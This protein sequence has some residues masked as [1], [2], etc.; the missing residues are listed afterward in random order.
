MARRFAALKVIIAPVT[1]P[2]ESLK[3]YRPLLRYLEGALGRPLHL[4]QRRTYGEVNE[5]LRTGNA[6]VAFVCSSSYVVGHQEFGLELLAIPQ[7]N[8]QHVYYSYLIVPRKS[9][10]RHLKDLRGNTFAFT[11]PLSNT[12]YIYPLYRLH[13]IGETPTTFFR[14]T[15]FTYGHDNSIRAV[16]DGMVDGAAVDS[17]IYKYTLLRYPKYRDAIR[18]LEKSPPFGMPPVVVRPD[19]DTAL[20]ARLRHVLLEAHRR[21]RGRQALH[22]LLIERFLPPQDN[23]YNSIREMFQTMRNRHGQN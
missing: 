13:R 6:D 18:I 8:G 11:D 23:D 15:L 19:L 12:G 10:A 17:V 16:A 2:Q 3:S 4:E 21:E 7:V 22:P 20:K 5:A 9:K 14:K 1:S